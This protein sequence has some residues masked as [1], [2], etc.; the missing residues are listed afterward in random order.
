MSTHV[1]RGVKP[2][3]IRTVPPTADPERGAGRQVI[4]EL[5]NAEGAREGLEDGVALGA[6]PFPGPSARS[7]R[8]RTS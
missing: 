8:R 2:D 5:R 1:P 6:L 7:A 4:V 3:A